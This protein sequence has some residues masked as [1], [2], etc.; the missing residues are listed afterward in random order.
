MIDQAAI[1][2]LMPLCS[3]AEQQ[4]LALRNKVWVA[5]VNAHAEQASKASAANLDDAQQRLIDL[6]DDLRAKYLPGT[7]KPSGRWF[8]NKQDAHEWY[9]TNGGTLTYSAFTRQEMIV[10]GRRVLRESVLELLNKELRSKPQ[11]GTP[12]HFDTARDEARLIRAK[13]RREEIRL[14]EEERQLDR[15]WILREESDD[16]LCVFVTLMRDQVLHHLYTQLPALI[17]AVGGIADRTADARAIIEQ[18]ALD[19][20]NEV[21]ATE[22]LDVEI[23]GDEEYAD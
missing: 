9:A 14:E 7:G 8:K 16:K 21:A 22:N 20:G 12:E 13:A 11:V 2:D 15:K 1:K 17:H 10:D 5:T 6:V 18:A 23:I 4:E 19:A 3:K